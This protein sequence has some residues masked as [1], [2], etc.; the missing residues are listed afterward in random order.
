MVKEK[1]RERESESEGRAK[2]TKKIIERAS[3]R[4]MYNKYERKESNTAH[5]K[6]KGQRALAR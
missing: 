6:V 1:L 4:V 3:V 5:P 2:C